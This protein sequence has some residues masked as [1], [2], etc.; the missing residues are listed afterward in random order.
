MNGSKIKRIRDMKKSTH[1]GYFIFVVLTAL[2]MACSFSSPLA[3][4]TFT[5]SS[6][7][8]TFT[9]KPTATP[10]STRTPRPTPTKE[11]I[12]Y[13]G[14]PCILWTSVTEKDL[15]TYLCIYGII[16][17]YGPISNKWH[18]ILFSPDADAFRVQDF[19]YYYLTPLTIGDC[20]VIYGKIRQNGPYLMITPEFDAP[21]RVRVGDARFCE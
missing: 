19:N 17:D 4:P 1:T 16:L 21:D 8:F 18:T 9:P 10:T 15:E 3:Q 13:D 7:P 12:T 20:V 5:P 6:V 2:S 14:T 11:P